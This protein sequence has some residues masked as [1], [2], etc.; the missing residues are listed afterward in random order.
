M[1]EGPYGGLSIRYR[2]VRDGLG[3][4]PALYI[5]WMRYDGYSWGRI[6]VCLAE[7]AGVKGKITP[8]VLEDWV[9]RYRRLESQGRLEQGSVEV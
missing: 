7:D 3:M 2:A 8:C 6:A 5:E 1:P 4:E 9:N